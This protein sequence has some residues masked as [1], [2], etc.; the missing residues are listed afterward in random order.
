MASH[1]WG[2]CFA[3]ISKVTMSFIDQLWH[4]RVARHNGF[5]TV[6][7][8]LSCPIN[9]HKENSMFSSIIQGCTFYC[10]L[11]GSLWYY[12]SRQRDRYI[13]GDFKLHLY[14]RDNHTLCRARQSVP[15]AHCTQYSFRG[16]TDVCTQKL[17]DFVLNSPWVKNLKI[18]L[19]GW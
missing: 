18:Y 2:K 7:D 17:F 14:S 5:Q 13:E 15:L 8:Q 6:W 9:E 19:A 12:H 3:S 10:C 4:F 16:N 1:G 11:S